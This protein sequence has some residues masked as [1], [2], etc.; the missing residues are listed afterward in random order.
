MLAFFTRADGLLRSDPWATR[1]DRV[2]QAFFYL[3]AYVVLFGMIYGAVMGSFGGFLGDRMWQV[4]FSAVK[5]TLLLFTTFLISL[6]NF[7]VLNTLFGL[8]DDFTQAIRALLATQAGL[9]MVLAALAPLTALFYAS[10]DRYS[11]ATL[12][13][14]LMFTIAS[15][16]AQ[17]LLRAHYRPLIRSNPR[18]RWLMWTWMVI[19]AFVGI[20]MGW[21]LRPFIGAPDLVVQFFREE[22]W[23]N[24]YVV[25]FQIIVRVLTGN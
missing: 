24:A 19:Y 17:W 14:A 10:M 11:M 21:V 2:V 25:V 20:Q 1:S 3:I 12:F 9:A 18:H 4:L 5:V 22:S 15:L 13:N 8:R 7:F 16:S 23:G 6:P